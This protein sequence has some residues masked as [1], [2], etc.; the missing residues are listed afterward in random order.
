[1]G[2]CADRAIQRLIAFWLACTSRADPST[3]FA[4]CNKQT[5]CRVLPSPRPPGPD[6]AFPALVDAM[7]AQHS[8]SDSGSSGD[9]LVVDAPGL[10]RRPCPSSAELVAHVAVHCGLDDEER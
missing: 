5:G 7:S 6:H 1:M 3:C 4:Q 10:K 9:L 8:R 2:G